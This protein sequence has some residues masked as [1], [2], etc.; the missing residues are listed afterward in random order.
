[1]AWIRTPLGELVNLDKVFCVEPGETETEVKIKDSS[2]DSEF[3]IESF[4]TKK[5]RDSYL[6][7]LAQFIN[8]EYAL[9]EG[10]PKLEKSVYYLS[11][12][13]KES[14]IAEIEKINH[15]LE[16]HVLKKVGFNDY[17]GIM[18]FK[19]CDNEVMPDGSK[20]SIPV[21]E[22]IAKQAYGKRGE[23][24]IQG[25]C[26]GARIYEVQVVTDN[27][28]KT[29]D[30]EDYVYVK[31]R[32]FFLEKPDSIFAKYL[33]DGEIDVKYGC[34]STESKCSICGHPIHSQ[35]CNHQIG[36]KY[37]GKLCY[38]LVCKEIDFRWWAD[39]VPPQ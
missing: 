21:L 37:D 32:A 30:G 6:T 26:I 13:P 29:I 11:S 23:L 10:I 2:C 22:D 8:Q 19:I 36:N 15:M 20:F 31:A 28:R 7:A 17:I 27:T 4:D 25:F 38:E 5:E 9:F 1:M 3:Y 14:Q 34:S 35:Y 24:Q 18:E 39:V 12:L 16:N 33:L